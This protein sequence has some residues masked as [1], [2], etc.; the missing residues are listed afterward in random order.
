MDRTGAFSNGWCAMTSLAI[1]ILC[2]VSGSYLLFSACA[3]GRRSIVSRS[4]EKRARLS[5]TE[6]LAQAGMVDV[7]P[8][9]FVLVEIVVFLGSAIGFWLVFGGIAA[10]VLGGLC[11][12]TGPIATYRARRVALREKASEAWPGLLEEIRLRAGAVGRSLPVA[13]F[14]AGR[15]APTVPMRNAFEAANR[16]WMLTT[17][18]VRSTTVLKRRLADPTADTICETLL[19]AHELGGNDVEARLAALIEDRRTD[20]RHRQEAKSRQAGVRFARWFV[21]IVPFGMALV[22]LGIG[23]GRA[24]Y[25][26]TGGQLAVGASIALT[27]LCWIWASQIMRLPAD[28]RVFRS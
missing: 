8:I 24:A 26:T 15:T 25:N 27:F 12:S 22:G 23:D 3:L 9:E 19:V 10:P 1:A 14:E 21:L 28:E 16:E 2:S 7:R 5:A 18:F 11:V 20:L 4:S 17:D 6:W 13:T